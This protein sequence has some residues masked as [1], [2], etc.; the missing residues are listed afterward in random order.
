MIFCHLH[1]CKSSISS[2][3]PASPCVLSSLRLYCHTPASRT[4]RVSAPDA[5]TG[6][7]SRERKT[8]GTCVS[9]AATDARLEN[10]KRSNSSTDSTV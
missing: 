3:H 8:R 7:P 6:F 2:P 10:I 1:R 4:Y 5:V 9:K